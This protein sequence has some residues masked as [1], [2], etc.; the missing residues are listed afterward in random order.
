MRTWKEVIEVLQRDA[1]RGLL[2]GLTNKYD[3]S[4]YPQSYK[5]FID[6]LK[7]YMI[8]F[9]TKIRA[10]VVKTDYDNCRLDIVFE[11][12]SKLYVASIY[13]WNTRILLAALDNLQDYV[14]ACGYKRKYIYLY[15]DGTNPFIGAS[16]PKHSVFKSGDIVVLRNTAPWYKY[17]FDHNKVF[18]IKSISRGTYRTTCIIE[19]A[20]PTTPSWSYY[21]ES[22]LKKLESGV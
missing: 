13:R 3:K 11:L 9:L 19:A 18:K 2:Q 6:E 15:E 7:Y 10:K 17:K 12:K 4:Q 20:G 22:N 8:E 16:F 1:M 5:T 14:L 21:P